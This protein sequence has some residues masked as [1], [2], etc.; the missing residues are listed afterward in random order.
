MAGCVFTP[1]S[2]GVGFLLHFLGGPKTM[3]HYRT[4]APTL[5]FN[6][7]VYLLL[8]PIALFLVSIPAGAQLSGKGAING[9]VTDSSG[10]VVSEATVQIRENSTNTAQ[11]VRTTP[12]GEYSFSLDPGKY[13][14][15][16]THPGFKSYTQQNIIVDALQTFSVD[17]SLPIGEVS[18]SV[19]VTDTP[20]MLETSN[21]SLGVTM[22]QEQY[23]ALPLIEDGGGQR[24][25]TDFASLLPGVNSSVTKGNLTTNAGI[26]N[27]SQSKGA[28]SAI[29]INGIPITSV[30]G[31]GDPR[32]ANLG[33]ARQDAIS[34]PECFHS[35]AGL[36]VQHNRA[37]GTVRFPLSA[38][39]LQT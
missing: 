11:T 21:A 19:T 35:Y 12:A 17:V 3:S 5:G 39:Q 15:T 25:A 10:A 34:G 14:I 8:A 1:S 37:N 36:Q 6:R 32:F 16:V 20:P 31:E 38:W 4:L 26:V 2:T 30:G 23:S 28:V 9:R 13:T 29:Y 22:E 18:E 27:G 7:R 24:R 33:H